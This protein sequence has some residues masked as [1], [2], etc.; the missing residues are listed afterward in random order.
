MSN[1]FYMAPKIFSE[2]V[3]GD[4]NEGSCEPT[5]DSRCG[6]RKMTRACIQDGTWDA[7]SKSDLEQYIP[8][9]DDS[10]GLSECGESVSPNSSR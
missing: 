4:W 10:K 8:C 6:Q 2:K 5:V 3:L 7:C 1:F 9:S